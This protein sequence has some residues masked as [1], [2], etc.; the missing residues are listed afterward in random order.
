MKKK[1][2]SITLSIETAIGGGSFGIFDNNGEIDLLINHSRRSKAEDLLSDINLLLNRNQIPKDEIEKI[3]YSNGPGSQTGIRIG[4]ATSKGLS[5]AL[6][7]DC[8]EISVLNALVFKT[9]GSGTIQTAVQIS[10][11]DVCRQIFEFYGSVKNISQPE[12]VNIN[13]FFESINVKSNI[14]RTVFLTAWLKTDTQIQ[15]MSNIQY[16]EP[17]ENVAHLLYRAYKNL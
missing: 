5:F 16:C 17:T 1:K 14:S 12:V 8:Q 15:N 2:K 11:N 6:G 3:I 13:Q 4:A 9:E 7:C 10:Q